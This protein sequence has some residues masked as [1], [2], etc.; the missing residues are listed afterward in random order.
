MCG[1]RN[2]CRCRCRHLDSGLVLKSSLQID[3]M[4]SCSP[5][6]ASCMPAKQT[7][8]DSKQTQDQDS[9]TLKEPLEECTGIQF[10]LLVIEML[11]PLNRSDSC[12]IAKSYI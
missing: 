3:C 4:P 10:F 5:V 12:L 6:K 8:V 11:N 7:T 1:S 9:L 2:R